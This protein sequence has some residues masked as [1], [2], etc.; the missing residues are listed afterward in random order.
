MSGHFSTLG[1]NWLIPNRQLH[2]KGN[3]KRLEQGVKYVYVTAAHG[4]NKYT[5]SHNL[6]DKTQTRKT[7]SPWE[8]D[9]F[10]D[11]FHM[12]GYKLKPFPQG[13]GDKEMIMFDYR[14]YETKS[15]RM[16]PVKIVED[17]LL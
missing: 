13:C 5:T 9:V 1:M 4:K 3:N 8:N 2:V 10:D 6:I 12:K 16:D 7:F 11:V 17:S 14:L 15:S